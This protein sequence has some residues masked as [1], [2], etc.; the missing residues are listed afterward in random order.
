MRNIEPTPSAQHTDMRLQ[1]EEFF[2]LLVEQ[3]PDAIVVIDLDT[4]RIV[5]ANSGPERLL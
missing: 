4:N 1:Q 2:C 5:E 3:G